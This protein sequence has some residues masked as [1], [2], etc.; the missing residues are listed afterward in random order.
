MI[1]SA[2]A[3]VLLDGR[4]F[5][6]AVP[7]AQNSHA[8]MLLATI[9]GPTTGPSPFLCISQPPNI[10]APEAEMRHW[11][12]G[13]AQLTRRSPFQADIPRLLEGK[14]ASYASFSW[15]VERLRSSYM[16][17]V[18]YVFGRAGG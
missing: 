14:Q 3:L 9:S 11:A 8:H 6:A 18:R 17:L 2:M 12:P 5:S 16:T 4:S 10:T 13:L 1:D 15:A 7:L